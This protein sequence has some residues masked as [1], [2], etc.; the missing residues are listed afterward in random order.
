MRATRREFVGLWGAAALKAAVA[1][2]DLILYNATIY[3]MDPANPQAQAVAIAG[4]RFLAVGSNDEVNNL[5]AAGVR[6]I[7]IGG[8][9]I[10]PGFI[11]A[12]LHSGSGVS[13]VRDVNCNLGSIAKVQAAIRE[14]AQ[15][16]GPGALVTGFN[17]DDTKMAEGRHMTKEDLD[18][19]VPDKPVAISHRGGHATWF[20]SFAFKLAGINE[21]TPD[22][23]GGRYRRRMSLSDN[24]GA[25][26]SLS[27][28]QNWSSI[29]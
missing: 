26:K 13:E 4:G 20:N 17:F 21:N 23:P 8:H 9:T 2:P 1:R 28:Q 19:A 29:W 24:R 18:A 11:D 12:H 7:D 15:K 14:R 10:V 25:T 3:T 22:P 16:L 27:P 6:K 5:A